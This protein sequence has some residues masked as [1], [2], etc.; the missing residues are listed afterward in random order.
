VTQ[1]NDP[2]LSDQR[3]PSDGSVTS[4]KIATGAVAN[5]NLA[6]V[7]AST[8]KGNNTFFSAPPQD[9]GLTD[10][11]DMLDGVLTAAQVVVDQTGGLAGPKVQQALQA[12]YA[13]VQAAKDPLFE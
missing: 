10:L 8:I 9:L 13:D 12:L 2:R 7:P 6:S 3:T 11:T 5:T 1:G 4:P